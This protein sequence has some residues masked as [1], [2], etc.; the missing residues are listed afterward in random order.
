MNSKAT[1]FAPVENGEKRIELSIEADQTV[2]RLSSWV[3]GLG[4]CGQKTMHVDAELLD[5]MHR[6]IGA[7][8]VRLRHR[9]R[10]NETTI[11]PQKVLDFPVIT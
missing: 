11:V 1:K 8:R 3:D 10:E 6:M 2:I 5:E 7:A 4:W 9:Q